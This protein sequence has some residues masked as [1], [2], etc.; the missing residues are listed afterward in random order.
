MIP[1]HLALLGGTTT[2]GDCLEA[3][4]L[5]VRPGLLADGP[6]IEEYEKAFAAQVGTSH[7]I[8][9]LNA[10]VGLYAILRSLGIGE[11]DD[12]LIQVPTHIVV[13]NAIRYTGARPVY[14]D[15]CAESYNLDFEHAARVCAESNAK[16]LLLQHT[17]GIPVDMDA[18][19][20]FADEHGI[21]LIEDCVH[22]LGATFRGRQTGSFGRA[23]FFS[24]EETKM[25]STSLGGMVVTD[26]DELATD[27]RQFQAQECPFP[28]TWLS[29][30]YLIKL[31]AYQVLTDPRV[32]LYT[33]SLYDLF[34]QFQ[35]LPKPV[36]REEWVGKRP[37]DYLMRL[38]NG[39]ALMGLR[40]LHR[41][42]ENL[43]HRRRIAS[44]YFRETERLGPAARCVYPDHSN[45][46]WCR[47]PI[48]VR[49]RANVEARLRRY[50]VPGI[51]FSSLLEESEADHYG[52]YVPG[53]CPNAEAVVNHVINLPT[54]GRVSEKD[55]IRLASIVCDAVED[56]GVPTS[57][58]EAGSKATS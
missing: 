24:T 34:G 26:D 37:D 1:R 18:A 36:S 19:Q 49:D 6:V 3:L 17:Y 38:S 58:N 50:A 44:I 5:L 27:I 41:L 9:F 16:A 2:Y 43:A 42:E 51:W 30:Q 13:A 55:A 8:S 7:G 29:A 32:H 57:M 47:F 25:I 35:P 12:V 53:S 10:R 11:G 40:Q 54:H 56:S 23:S 39:Q 20:A 33:R 52:G 22:S 15:C 46:S 28:G 21:V 31:I 4:K 45:P 14:V 48:R